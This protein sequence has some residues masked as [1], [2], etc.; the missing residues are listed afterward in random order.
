MSSNIKNKI[1]IIIDPILRS[2]RK[3]YGFLRSI[4]LLKKL[5]KIQNFTFVENF[6]RPFPPFTY[7]FIV[8]SKYSDFTTLSSEICQIINQE[9]EYIS[10]HDITYHLYS[11]FINLRTNLKRL[12]F[13][14]DNIRFKLKRENN[15]ENKPF[16]EDKG[17]IHISKYQNLLKNQL[18]SEGI[19]KLPLS[20]EK[21]T[22]NYILQ[23]LAYEHQTR[24][25]TKIRHLG[26]IF[27]F[28]NTFPESV[29]WDMLLY[30]AKIVDESNYQDII[31]KYL[32]I[33]IEN[34]ITRIA[35]NFFD[36]L[37]SKNFDVNKIKRWRFQN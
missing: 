34:D 8:L 19:N 5:Y 28:Y 16:V 3:Y 13:V 11:N 25:E 22:G 30:F 9:Q 17:L 18:L 12:Y 1:F 14:F 35:N 23:K 31:T 24:M 6:N 15:L 2:E 32:R 26:D 36:A 27:D 7:N 21:K 37:K 10:E 20:I 33:Y 29:I 4:P